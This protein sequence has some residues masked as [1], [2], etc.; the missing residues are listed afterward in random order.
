M[1]PCVSLLTSQHITQSHTQPLP[2]S[3]PL[4]FPALDS[5]AA[6]LTNSLSSFPVGWAESQPVRPMQEHPWR[7]LA[8]SQHLPMWSGGNICNYRS[9][10]SGDVLDSQRLAAAPWSWVLSAQE[11]LHPSPASLYY[12]INN[13]VSEPPL[14][15]PMLA[16]TF[17]LLLPLPTWN[18]VRLKNGLWIIS[19]KGFLCMK[20]RSKSWGA[21]CA[22]LFLQL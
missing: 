10:S 20:N 7:S 3:L 11:L 5:G 18:P 13:S 15:V 14:M 9:Q 16:G 19:S 17:P 1:C 22:G 21:I 2:L 6:L 4:H 8:P 12:C